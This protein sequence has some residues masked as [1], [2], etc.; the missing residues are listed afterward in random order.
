M[1][2]DHY[3]EQLAKV[4]DKMVLVGEVAQLAR[5]IFRSHTLAKTETAVHVA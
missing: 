3:G 2:I 4:M 5:R 1:Q